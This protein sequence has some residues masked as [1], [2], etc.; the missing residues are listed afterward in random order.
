MAEGTRPPR[1]CTAVGRGLSEERAQEFP[2]ELT[3][4]FVLIFFLGVMGVRDLMRQRRD[5]V[6]IRRRLLS[7]P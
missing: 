1:T 7:Y 3:I 6:E 2:Q 5:S 4:V